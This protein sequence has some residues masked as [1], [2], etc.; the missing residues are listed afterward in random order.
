L[1]SALSETFSVFGAAPAGSSWEFPVDR[2][3][4]PL[5][6]AGRD[7]MLASIKCVGK[8]G[9]LS[10]WLSHTNIVLGN[11]PRGMRRRD[12][13]VLHNRGDVPVVIGI[14][15]HNSPTQLGTVVH[16]GTGLLSVEAMP[17]PGAPLTAAPSSDPLVP[18]APG[19]Q[20]TLLVQLLITGAGGEFVTPFRLSLQGVSSSVGKSWHCSVRGFVD[21][22][23]LSGTL[24]ALLRDEQ[25]DSLR[26]R[27]VETSNHVARVLAR[28]DHVSTVSIRHELALV[29]PTLGLPSLQPALVRPA[30]LAH[31]HLHSFRR[32]YHNRVPMRLTQQEDPFA[33]L[34]A[35]LA[36]HTVVRRV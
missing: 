8:G 30:A 1:S 17:P 26:A 35:M 20:R 28:V 29:E 13:I 5:Y 31:V 7:T 11:V 14:S 6:A 4:V 33:P 23:R 19:E 2:L 3:T 16:G 9:L 32:W 34:H 12:E 22:I 25:L 27:E 21:D 36:P 10:V 15:V 18:L 24:E